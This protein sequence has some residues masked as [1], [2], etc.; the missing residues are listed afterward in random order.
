MPFLFGP[1]IILT[2]KSK[3][4]V[5]EKEEIGV[6]NDDTRLICKTPI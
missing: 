3:K 6:K 2:A 5:N 1:A 4:K